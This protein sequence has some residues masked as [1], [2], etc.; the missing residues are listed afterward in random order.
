MEREREIDLYIY[1]YICMKEISVCIYIY[2]YDGRCSYESGPQEPLLAGGSPN[3][4]A[5]TAQMH[6]AEKNY[7]RV[8][9]PL[10]STCTKT[11]KIKVGFGKIEVSTGVPKKSLCRKTY[12][13]EMR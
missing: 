5:A 9:T 6:S 4:Q 8:P 13:K 10:G 2:I 7:R 3:H 1:V 12:V 11:E